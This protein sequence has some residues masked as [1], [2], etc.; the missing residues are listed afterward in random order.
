MHCGPVSGAGYHNGYRTGRVSSAESAIECS[1]PQIAD[2]SEPFR[3][4]IREL[5]RGWTEELEAARR[6]VAHDQQRVGQ[7]AAAHVL[8]E[9]AATG[10]VLPGPRRQVQQRLFAVR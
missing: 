4:R 8:E 6:S 1:T 2:R 10:H 3:T 5:V 7:T 9:L